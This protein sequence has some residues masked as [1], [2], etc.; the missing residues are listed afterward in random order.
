MTNGIRP[1]DPVTSSTA[2]PMMSLSWDQVNKRRGKFIGD[3]A[4]LIPLTS[5]LGIQPQITPNRSEFG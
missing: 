1:E 5:I 3:A 4:T 2:L